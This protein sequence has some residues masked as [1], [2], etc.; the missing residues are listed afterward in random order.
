MY[1]LAEIENGVL[2]GNSNKPFGT[3]VFD[4]QD[5]RLEYIVEG[6]EPRIHFALVCG[7]KSCPPIKL[8]DA[9]NVD[10]ALNA[11]TKAF[12]EEDVQVDMRTRTVVLSK[13]LYWYKF[14]FGGDN[15]RLLQWIMP[16]LRDTVRSDVQRLLGDNDFTV[17][18]RTYDWSQN[19]A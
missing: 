7:A 18:H 15:T 6:G 13:I 17:R 2:R 8:F 14:D 16:Y 4:S 9:A 1:S 10:E 19:S 12:L 5:P 3:S 11:A